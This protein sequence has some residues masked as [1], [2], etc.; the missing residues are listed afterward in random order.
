MGYW[1][2]VIF[3]LYSLSFCT[4]KLCGV[5]TNHR[6]KFLLNTFLL[7]FL[8][9]SSP[10]FLNMIQDAISQLNATLHTRAQNHKWTSSNSDTMK[11]FYSYDK[12][13]IWTCC[14]CLILL[15]LEYI[16][17]TRNKNT[18]NVS[19]QIHSFLR[20]LINN[21]LFGCSIFLLLCQTDPCVCDLQEFPLKPSIKKDLFH[22]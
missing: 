5:H 16:D 1:V 4:V 6:F 8:K 21:D 10:R 14:G 11:R 12:F 19:Y 18:E 17:M 9:L 3:I 2:Y 15:F 20:L 22:H 13:Q 7:P